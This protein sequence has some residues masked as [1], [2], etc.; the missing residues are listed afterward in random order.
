MKNKLLFIIIILS[1][2]LTLFFLFSKDSYQYPYWD[3]MLNAQWN[4]S[5]PNWTWNNID[6][7]KNNDCKRPT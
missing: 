1:T 4:N 6:S 5:S 2:A 3:N 7:I